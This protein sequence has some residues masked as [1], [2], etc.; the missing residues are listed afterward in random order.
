MRQHAARR[1]LFAISFR[2]DKQHTINRRRREDRRERASSGYGLCR[3]RA[4]TLLF[5]CRLIAY[6]KFGLFS[7]A[8][9]RRAQPPMARCLRAN[10]PPAC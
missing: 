8:A 4:R 2:F 7:A 1:G 3:R 5:Q 9:R 10:T 6:A